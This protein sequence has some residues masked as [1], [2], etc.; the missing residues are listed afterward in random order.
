MSIRPPLRLRR[1]TTAV[2]NRCDMTWSRTGGEPTSYRSCGALVSCGT[3]RFDVS[4]VAFLSGRAS[5]MS[6][7]GR[8]VFRHLPL[9]LQSSFNEFLDL[10]LL[11]C[12]CTLRWRTCRVVLF[13]DLL[14]ACPNR[15]IC[16]SL[17]RFRLVPG[18]L[19]SIASAYYPPRKFVLE[20][21]A[22]SSSLNA[23]CPIGPGGSKWENWRCC[24][25]CCA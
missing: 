21:C 7:L 6:R 18:L 23:S 15:S 2:V 16:F 4:G 9:P 25:G 22:F 10:P 12:P 8:C 3:V 14:I 13:L 5:R 1:H 19:P 20:F 17:V 24:C 11:L